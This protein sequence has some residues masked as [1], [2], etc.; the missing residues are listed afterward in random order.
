[1][2]SRN[3]D[4]TWLHRKGATP[5]H[6]GS[7]CIIPGSMASGVAIGYGLG[8]AEYLES[9]SHG[10]GRRMGRNQAKRTLSVDAFATAMQGVVCEPTVKDRLDEAPEAYKDFEAVLEAQDGVVV[11]ITDIFRPIINVKG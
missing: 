1:M 11:R 10:A 6:H 4:G 8:N 7:D 5:A 3:T 9:C 2:V